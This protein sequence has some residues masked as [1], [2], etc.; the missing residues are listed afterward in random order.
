[1]DRFAVI[2]AG[3][4]GSEI[5]AALAM[6][7]KHVSLIIPD[8]GIGAP[9]Y[10]PDLSEFL[11]DFF[12]KKGVE[13]I[14]G[15]YLTGMEKRQ[16]EYILTARSGREFAAQAIVAGI[17]L[18]PNIELPKAAGLLTGDG[19][20]VDKYLLTSQPDIYAAGDVAEFYNPALRKRMRVE[21]E[22]NANTM[23]LQAGRN[24][25]GASEP[26]LHLPFFYSDLFEL[27]YEAVGELDSKS[28][29]VADWKEPYQ[30]GV[31]YYLKEGRI[32]G[33]LLWNVWKKI[34]AARQLISDPGPFTSE[35]LIGRLGY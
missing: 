17:G 5:A 32:R 33:V 28:T 20:I 19:I 35:N 1:M 8:D 23:G 9:L 13:V 11:N 34:E 18:V 12:R 29:V 30:T 6:N 2:G 27:G 22:D 15:E 24:M 26:Y 21:H 3:F 25:A 14:T 16:E 4:I 7:G 10:P 31:L